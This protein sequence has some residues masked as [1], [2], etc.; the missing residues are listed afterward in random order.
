[1]KYLYINKIFFKIIREL[2]WSSGATVVLVCEHRPSSPEKMVKRVNPLKF[3]FFLSVCSK[4]IK[5]K[6][7]FWFNEYQTVLQGITVFS[8]ICV[9]FLINIETYLSIMYQIISLPQNRHEIKLCSTWKYPA[10]LVNPFMTDFS[11]W[12]LPHHTEYYGAILTI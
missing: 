3:T 2:Q 11:R 1:M 6:H 8:V 10:L 7:T 12:A 5:I 4:Q 9:Y